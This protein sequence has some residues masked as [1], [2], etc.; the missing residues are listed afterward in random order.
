MPRGT[1]T[2]TR[3]KP[4]PAG[5]GT[6]REAVEAD[7]AAIAAS[8]PA[9]ARSGLARLA[10]ALASRVDDTDNS[11]TS[12]SMC[13]RA[14]ADVLGQLRDLTPSAKEA[15]GIDELTRKREDRRSAATG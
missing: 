3:R 2:T 5:D 14:L 1:K 6:V 7:L 15:D 4:P 10:L 9:L 13:G 8:E 11:A 12:V